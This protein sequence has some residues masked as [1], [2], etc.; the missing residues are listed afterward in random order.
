MK[1]VVSF[2]GSGRVATQMA[3]AFDEA[4]VEVKQIFSRNLQHAEI[5]ASKLKAKPEAIDQLGALNDE[6]DLIIIAIA[7]D[8]IAEVVTELHFKETVLAHT[9]GS[10]PLSALDGAA[11]KTAI[12]YPLQSFQTNQKAYWKEIPIFLEAKNEKDYSFL[13]KMAGYLSNTVARLDSEKRKKL[14]LAAVFANNFTNHFYHIAYQILSKEEMEFKWL[15]P[16]IRNAVDRLNEA[17]PVELQTGPAKR[18]DQK[19]ID[20]HMQMLEGNETYQKLYRDLSQIILS[21]HKSSE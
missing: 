6:S 5:L 13:E 8:A 17:D 20:K 21:K 16:L 1:P 19:T 3:Q 7:D 14:H 18:G 9:S 11:E 4:G 12:F 10:V 15:L 2:I